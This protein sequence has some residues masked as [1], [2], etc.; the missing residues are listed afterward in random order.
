[1]TWGAFGGQVDKVDLLSGVLSQNGTWIILLR[2]LYKLFAYSHF[3]K[4]IYS[5]SSPKTC[6]PL[7]LFLLL[8]SHS[9]CSCIA[10]GNALLVPSFCG[11]TSSADW[12][13]K[14]WLPVVGRAGSTGSPGGSHNSASLSCP[15]GNAG[16][17]LP[18]FVFEVFRNLDFCSKSANLGNKFMLKVSKAKPKSKAVWS[19]PNLSAS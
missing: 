11:K 14:N 2:Y 17:M 15:C 9:L 13:I 18:G 3:Y 5:A 16:P 10:A 4:E 19:S 6:F 8:F 7:S 12:M 1:M